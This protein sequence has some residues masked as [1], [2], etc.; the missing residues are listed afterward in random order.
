[1]G[2]LYLLNWYWRY[3]PYQPVIDN[4]FPFNNLRL[5]L[6]GLHGAK[7]SDGEREGFFSE[8]SAPP[9][10]IRRLRQNNAAAESGDEDG[11]VDD[12]ES[13]D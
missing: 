6:G 9:G 3:Q 5:E 8:V 1:M 12:E 2:G 10:E 11:G 4:I 13:D 7:H